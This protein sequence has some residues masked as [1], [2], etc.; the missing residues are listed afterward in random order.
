MPD[1][2]TIQEAR[3]GLLVSPF[4]RLRWLVD[5]IFPPRC[6]GCGRVDTIWCARCRAEVNAI[7]LGA[8]VEMRDPL[9]GVAAT[10]THQG[11]LQ[12]ALWAL[13]YENMPELAVPLGQRLAAHFEQLHWTIDMIV[14]VPL[15][16]KRLRERGYNQAQRL[17]ETAA[18][19]L[20]LPCAADAL[21]RTRQ[22][23]SQVTLNFD[24]RQTNMQ[25]AFVA[26]P[27]SVRSQS[28]LLID[29]VYTTGATLAAC[30]Q[31]ALDAGAAAVYGLTVT[32]PARH[33]PRRTA[34][35]AGVSVSSNPY[36]GR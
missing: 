4:N 3:F 23:Q 7:P 17:G 34:E 12:R 28:I 13:K 25:D 33:P 10:G 19:L 5:L 21:T 6:A 2:F 18:M 27:E 1:V 31:A 29:D 15:H 32:T 26:N 8:W 9:S 36:S 14:P 20:A 24:Q 35:T 30:A 11:K 22:T 16:M